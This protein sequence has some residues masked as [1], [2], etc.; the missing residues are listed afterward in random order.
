VPSQR[1]RYDGKGGDNSDDRDQ[2]G[3]RAHAAIIA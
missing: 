3:A 1:D 2:D